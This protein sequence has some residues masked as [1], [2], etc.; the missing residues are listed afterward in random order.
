MQSISHNKID[1]RNE[2][3]SGRR[4]QI[5]QLLLLASFF[6]GSRFSPGVD[7]LRARFR[8]HPKPTSPSHM[9]ALLILND[10]CNLPAALQRHM[11]ASRTLLLRAAKLI[12]IVGLRFY[13]CTYVLIIILT[14][15]IIKKKHR[16]AKEHLVYVSTTTLSVI[17]I[18]V[19]IFAVSFQ[20]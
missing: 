13:L 10:A 11:T 18:F 6:F 2:L 12:I 14:Q 20:F 7:T 17:F 16:A 3:P 15:A 1:A 5:V 19:F 9:S 8:G 4:L